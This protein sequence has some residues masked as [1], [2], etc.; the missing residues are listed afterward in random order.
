MTDARRLDDVGVA[1]LIASGSKA[2][3][4]AASTQSGNWLDV[5]Q[6]EG[7]LL[8]VVNVASVTGTGS[9]ALQA[10]QSAANTG[11]SAANVVEP[12]GSLLTITAAGTYMMAI[13]QAKVGL[14]FFGLTGTLTGFTGVQLSA[15]VVGRSSNGNAG[16]P[17]SGIWAIEG[18]GGAG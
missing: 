5:S 10:S 6:C 1:E 12:R 17:G 18:T 15:M 8:V 11:A 4:A 3:S 9:L 7:D 14:Q 2:S 13:D 16:F